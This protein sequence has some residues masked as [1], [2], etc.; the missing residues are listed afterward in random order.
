MCGIY[1]IFNKN[2]NKNINDLYHG[3]KKLQHR[4]KDGYGIVY[5]LDDISLVTTKGE[6]EIKKNLFN[7]VNEI[8][9]KSCIGHL[10]YS[11]SGTSIKNGLL[12]RTELQPIRG[13]DSDASGPFYIAHNGNIPNVEN[14][15]TTYIRN[16]LEKDGSMED[17][18]INLINNIPA[19]FSIVILT[20]NNNM[21]ILR[22]RFGI[23]PLCIGKNKDKYHISS[24]SCAFSNDVNFIRDVKPGE[25]IRI[26]E[27]GLKTLYL[28]D[29]SVLNLCS[30]EILYFLNENSYVDGIQIKNVRKNLGKLLARK[31]NIIDM[32]CKEDYLVV[33]IPLSGI[34]YGKSYAKELGINYCQVVHKNKNSSR[35]FIILDN[36]E[37]KKACDKKFNYNKELIK[38][39]KIIIVDDTIVRGNVIKSIIKSIKKC[40]AKEIHIR[41]PGPPV[42]DIC[43][44]GISIQT[45][46]ELIMNNNN[47]SIEGVCKEIN[48]DSLKY[49]SVDE[50]EYFPK[51]TYNQCFTGYIN[52]IIKSLKLI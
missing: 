49:L 30:F 16:L 52:P 19:A 13:Y 24:E 7:R 44:L 29:N 41:I 33:G 47:N 21:Y 26:D 9:C 12:K 37:R 51:N 39:K 4:G 35:T 42:I 5:L 50:L 23:R 34:L 15:D 36:E 22:D 14:H 17:K 40:G 8:R 6:G 18:L 48:A 25:L 3:L 32:E 43:E 46:E 1:A 27:T 31:E 2:Y 38:D 28:R 11:T 20:H 10:R 45:K